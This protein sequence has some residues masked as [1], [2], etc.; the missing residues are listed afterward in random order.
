MLL[1]T[2]K[3]LWVCPEFVYSTNQMAQTIFHKYFKVNTFFGFQ[4]EAKRQTGDWTTAHSRLE[5]T[6]MWYI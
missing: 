4:A 3:V 6:N 2:T 5:N 1:L